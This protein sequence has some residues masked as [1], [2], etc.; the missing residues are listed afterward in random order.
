[1][2]STPA[3]LMLSDGTSFNGTAIGAKKEAFGEVVFNTSQT[4]YQEILT[5]PSY[6]GQIVNFTFPHIGNYGVNPE[7]NESPEP[8]AAGLICTELSPDLG[9]WRSKQSLSDW[10]VEHDISG[11]S[12]VDTRALTLHLRQHGTMNGYISSIDLSP[13]SL[14]EKT[15]ASLSHKQA[16]Y[17]FLP[18]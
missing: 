7:Y 14:L 12:D 9:H 5:D 2:N 15:W 4:G 11:I 17:A 10:L 3:L 6:T 18:L 8:R 1:M 16:G 13:A